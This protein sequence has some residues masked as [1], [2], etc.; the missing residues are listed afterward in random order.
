MLKRSLA[1]LAAVLSLAVIAGC[2]P[3]DTY[4]R[5]NFPT[6][7]TT[8]PEAAPHHGTPYDS[9][10]NLPAC[11]TVYPGVPSSG[12]WT[13]S[14]QA[15]Y[16]GCQFR[17]EGITVTADNVIL[18]AMAIVGDRTH[19]VLAQGENLS[20]RFS[21]II[22]DP[23][24]TYVGPA[25]EPCQSAVAYGDYEILASEVSGCA[26]GF[27]A[28]G[29]VVITGSFVH[30]LWKGCHPVNT[31]TCTHND[32]VQYPENGGVHGDFIFT[33]NAFYLDSCDSNRHLQAKNFQGTVV[34]EENFIYGGNGLQMN[35]GTGNATVTLN[36]NTFAG[37]KD[38]GPFNTNQANTQM[39]GL[40]GGNYALVAHDSG[41]VFEM[42]GLGVDTSDWR[43]S[44]Y[45]CEAMPPPTTTTTAP[46]TTTTAPTT[47]TTV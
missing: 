1:A 38:H 4:D 31:G 41:N 45:G 37:W 23:D 12:V 32:V 46:T 9:G 3:N 2:E 36:S 7:G 26:D 34:W 11:S 19:L 20:I 16:E 18:N 40:L 35:D 30:D 28:Q 17:G 47:T 14:T 22:P 39:I 21:V 8:G 44:P 42:D 33:G 10:L 15:T 5:A 27:K 6:Y 29:S 43:E 24:G 13:I 25:G